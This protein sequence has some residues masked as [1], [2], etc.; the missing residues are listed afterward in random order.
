[1]TLRRIIL[2]ATLLI[3]C[4]ASEAITL[5]ERAS[6]YLNDFA[7][8]IETDKREKIETLCRTLEA[9]LD[10]LEFAIVT[11]PTLDNE[12]L[13]NVAVRL[14]EQWKIGKRGKDN[15]LLL[16]VALKERRVKLEVGYGLEPILPDGLVGE[17]LDRGFVNTFRL[18]QNY[19][20]AVYNSVSLVGLRVAKIQGIKLNGVA[21]QA[22]KR[23]PQH[24][25]FPLWWLLSFILFFLFRGRRSRFGM[26][27]GFGG[28]GFGGFSGFGGGGFG[29]FG[30]GMSGGG[31]AGRS[32]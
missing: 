12:P 17:L 19:G 28:G 22:A 23:A 1:M 30:G 24:Q 21:L 26:P 8:I 7:K 20:D 18:T 2:G 27:G 32:F 3:A 16:L 11:L 10:G 5:P 4:L 6:G 14:F 13:E 9:Q 29:G 25:R 15:G 31:G